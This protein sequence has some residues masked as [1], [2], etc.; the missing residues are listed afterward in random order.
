MRTFAVAVLCLALAIVAAS[1]SIVAL[2]STLDGRPDERQLVE[3]LLR[4]E[5]H[6]LY[7]MPLVW[8]GIASVVRV[9]HCWTTLCSAWAFAPMACITA[10]VLWTRRKHRSTDFMLAG[11]ACLLG[12]A[13][14]WAAGAWMLSRIEQPDEAGRWILLMVGN[15]FWG[16]MVCAACAARQLARTRRRDRTTIPQPAP[17]T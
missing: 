14:P 17:A 4:G 7:L 8:Q 15:V 12:A 9:P 13:L 10:A 6:R 11:L 3:L 5:V 2:L 1:V 16:A